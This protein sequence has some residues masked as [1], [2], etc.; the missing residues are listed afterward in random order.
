MGPFHPVMKPFYPR[1]LP[2]VSEFR[3]GLRLCFPVF[4]SIPIR[5]E[6]NNNGNKYNTGLLITDWLMLIDDQGKI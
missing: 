2:P 4:H 1:E 3:G 6:N 5:F